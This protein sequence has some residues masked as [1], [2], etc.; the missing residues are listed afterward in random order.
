MPRVSSRTHW[1][2]VV[3]CRLQCPVFESLL[4]CAV[5]CGK[6]LFSYGKSAQDMEMTLTFP[7]SSDLGVYVEQGV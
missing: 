3:L 6:P 5:P 2:H 7:Q 1:S 4:S